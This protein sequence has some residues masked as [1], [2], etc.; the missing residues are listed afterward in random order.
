MDEPVTAVPGVRERRAADLHR[1]GI[2]RVRDLLVN[3][4]RR[5]IDMSEVRTIADARIGSLVTIAGSVH[6]VKVKRPRRN[7][8]IV[9][10][11][12]VDGTATLIVT[13]FNQR[14]L[15]DKL[16]AGMRVALSGKLEFDYGFK[17]MTNP[18]IEPIEGEASGLILPVHPASGKVSPQ[19]MRTLIK[20]ALALTAGLFDPLPLELRLKYRLMSRGM[21]LRCVHFPTSMDEAAAARRRLAFEEILLV[22][23]LMMTES[24]RRSAG[25]ETTAHVV[26]GPH[27][28]ALAE[29]LPFALTRDQAAARDDLLRAMADQGA[30]NHMILGDVGTGKT[31]VAAFGMAAAADSGGQALVLAPTEVLAEQHRKSL[32]ALLEAAGL[33]VA[34]L[35]GSTPADERA[36]IV[37]GLASGA[38]D[39]LIGTHALMEDDVRPVRCTLVVIDEQQ[40]FGVDQRARLLAKGSAPDALYLTA[41]PIP[42][43]LALALFGN[44]TLSYIHERPLAGSGRTTTVVSKDDRGV[45]YDAAKQ[46][47]A[48]GEQ[49]YVVCALIGLDAQERKAAAGR[50]RDEEDEAYY[51]EVAIEGTSGDPDAGLTAAV[52][53][54]SFLRTNIFPDHQVELLHGSMP[55]DEKRAVMQRFAAGEVEVLVTTT[56]VEVGVDV[57]NATVMIIEDADRFGLAQLHQ[58]R[59]RVG[60]GDKAGQVYLVSASK[61][62]P[63]LDRLRA[64]V[65]TDDGF[66][67]AEEDLA[68]R[69]EGDILGNRQSGASAMRLVNVVRDAAMIE[70]AHACAAAILAADPALDAPSDAALAREMRAV[71][72]AERCEYTVVGG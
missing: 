19:Q 5:Y 24:R 47:L 40:R 59:G 62:R 23:L 39:V 1:M 21:A 12:V 44:L 29:A 3:Y 31:A 71:F 27:V 10:I 8:H 13:A 43:S 22:Q 26:D 2:R 41:T 54:A 50:G 16:S 38:I 35:T 67:L 11:T 64:L 7:L 33:R 68:L 20:S 61:K 48:R 34:L 15:A 28:R 6:E 32:G 4:P 49:V 66:E 58:L 45:A 18:T 25:L 52:N 42:R 46:A 53:E 72:S 51:P 17:R 36:S 55:S 63:A 14:W 9:E 37:D 60:R 56:V 70:E 30:A 65:R 57:P 69:R